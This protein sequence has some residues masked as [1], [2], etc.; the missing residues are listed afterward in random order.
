M[1][2]GDR[3][4]TIIWLYNHVDFE[5]FIKEKINFMEKDKRSGLQAMLT[6]G[7]I[8]LIAGLVVQ[9]FRFDFSSGMF[10]MGV[11]FTLSGLVGL[12]MPKSTEKEE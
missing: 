7:I 12:Y 8:F 3:P 11:I 2:I 6:I 10:T 5:I 1:A 4:A 9:G